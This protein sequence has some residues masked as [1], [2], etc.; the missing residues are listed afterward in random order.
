MNWEKNPKANWRCNPGGDAAN[1]K[2]VNNP[3][4]YIS[5][6]DAC[7]YADW[8]S[9][10]TGK[11]WRLPTEAEWE[12]AA[13][14]GQNLR[15]AGTDNLEA[16]GWFKTNAKKRLHPVGTKMPNFFG[17]YDMSGNAWEWCSDYYTEDFYKNSPAKNPTGAKSG[18][19]RVIRGGSWLMD[20]QFCRTTQRGDA[21]QGSFNNNIGFRL[22][23]I[24]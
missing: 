11:T 9:K 10:K 23:V 16:A 18:Q 20:E 17:L 13:K 4:V 19:S 8:L 15:Y 24:Q 12:F 2:E 7:A 21:P 1:E 14:A 6:N 22:V 3:V 5:W